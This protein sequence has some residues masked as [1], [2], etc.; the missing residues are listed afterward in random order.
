[1]MKKIGTDPDMAQVLEKNRRPYPSK[2]G[3][4]QFKKIW[5]QPE[6]KQQPEQRRH[7]RRDQ[8]D[9]ADDLVRLLTREVELGLKEVLSQRHEWEDCPVVRQAGQTQEPE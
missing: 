4:E 8:V 6:M 1:M 2:D 9:Q 5:M 3:D 7:R